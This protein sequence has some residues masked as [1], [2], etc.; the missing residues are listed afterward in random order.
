MF[1]KVLFSIL[2][3]L[4]FIVH[5]QPDAYGIY[6][7]SGK[8]VSYDELVKRCG[9]SDV[10]FFGELHDNAVAHWLEFELLKGLAKVKSNKVI[11]GA[12]MFEADDQIVLN[13]YLN[14]KISEKS[15]NAEC[16]LWPNYKT[17]YKPLV[18]FCKSSD[19]EFIATN[20]PRRYASM[21]YLKGLNSLDSLSSSA[22]AYLPP[23]PF[24][25]DAELKTYKEIFSG[26]GH[27]GANLPL[28]QAL[29]DAMMGH[30]IVR[31]FTKGHTF[32]HYNGAYHSNYG[33]GTAWYVKKY[34]PSLSTIVI[35]VVEQE[36]VN[37]LEKEHLG[38]ADLIIVVDKDFTR[39]QQ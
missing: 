8:P 6:T 25:Y 3:S 39:T 32:I 29:K 5:A 4:S 24:P 15:F 21:V 17:D 26:A 35:S 34:D 23:L 13:E 16:K 11:A 9:G 27:G 10:V 1:S 19:I 28:S 38:L 33:E 31:N 18:E 20:V 2:I 30:S 22:K 12:E 37:A 7:S 36:S 14:G